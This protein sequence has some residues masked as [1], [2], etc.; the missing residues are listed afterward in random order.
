MA[1]MKH[2]IHI[3]ALALLLALAAP[4]L[5]RPFCAPQEYLAAQMQERY[6]ETLA[7]SGLTDGGNIVEIWASRETGTWTVLLIAADGMACVVQTGKH[8]QDRWQD[9]PEGD[10][11]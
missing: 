7:H 1:K 2:L 3:G 6:G 10:P 8:W 11:P 5:A 4:A 9:V